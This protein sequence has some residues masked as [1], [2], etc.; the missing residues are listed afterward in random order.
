MGLQPGQLWRSSTNQL[1]GLV[2]NHWWHS[3]LVSRWHQGRMWLTTSPKQ[4][5]SNWIWLKR[6]KW[7]QMLSS[8][9]WFS[10]VFQV[11]STVWWQS[12]TSAQ[13]RGTT[14]WSRTWS[15]SQQPGVSVFQARHRWQH[16][17][18]P[19]GSLQS[20][21]SV[22]RWGTELRTATVG[23]R[24]LA[25]TVVRRGIWL[26]L[27]GRDSKR[28][29]VED[30]ARVNPATIHQRTSSASGL[31]GLVATT[32]GALSFSLTLGATA[33]WS[34]TKSSSLIWTRV[35]WQTYATLTAVVQR[36]KD[37]W[38][39]TPCLV[40][41][42]QPCFVKDNTGRSCLL[43][44]KDAF[45]VPSYARNLVSVKR[46]TDKGAMIQFNDDP[47]IKMPNG[48]VVPMMTNDELFSVMAQPVEMGSLAMM[49]HSIKHWHRVMGH[50]NWHDVAK[51]QQEVVGMNISGSEKK[52]NCNICCTEK[53]K[54]ASI[55]KTWGTRA[56]TKLAIVH[57]DVLGP[58][59][60]ESHEG[61]RYAVGFIDSYSRFGAVYPMKSKD[62]VTAK[63]Q[64][65]IIDVGRPGTLVSDGAL[66]FKSKQFS[67][68]CTS[69]GIKQEFSA[70]YTPEENGKIERAW[71]T[72]TGMT[73]CMMATAAVP[74]QFWPFALS[75]AIYLKNRSIHSAHGKTPFEMFH[76]SKPDLSNLHVFGCQSFVLNEVRKK[77][78][79]KA[80]EAILL[81][82][83]GTSKAYVVASTDGSETR[84]PKVWVSRNVNFNDDVFPYQRGSAVTQGESEDDDASQSDVDDLKSG[85]DE[86]CET[87][88][89][90]TRAI[91]GDSEDNINPDDGTP[92]VTDS[93][94]AVQ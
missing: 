86:Q 12:S 89:T 18:Q 68:L 30:V 57:T 34:R 80:R 64:R 36:S 5:G 75:T 2:F 21:S 7:S 76:G 20:A 48:T 87:T 8:Q 10:R 42:Y 14:R 27:A 53:A 59:Q 40:I 41:R 58:I 83:S 6:G 19:G 65:F 62:E 66:E 9:R 79:S 55:P 38:F 67:D 51:L 16:F 23:R 60:Q 13:Q 22:E 37:I 61:F 69:N 29:Q 46:L 81:G 45:W 31:S 94:T 35:F 72:V 52:T 33:S 93:T 24:G 78:D 91:Q 11:T 88:S 26:Q 71:G 15:T 84:A 74:K 56:K 3:S 90:K 44:L 85:S 25:S 49:S 4:K 32:R 70:P 73:R 50:N 1:N 17:T 54:R 77:L 43:E 39:V 28:A 63:L 82:Y 47:T 92:N